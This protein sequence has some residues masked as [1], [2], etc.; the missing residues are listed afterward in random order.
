MSSRRSRSR[1]STA[2][3][4]AMLDQ[5]DP[6]I[7]D[8]PDETGLDALR[9]RP[10]AELCDEFASRREEATAWLCTLSAAQLARG[11]RHEVAGAITIRDVLH[12]LAYHDL[13]HVAQSARLIAARM[14]QRRGAMRDA[15]PD[16]GG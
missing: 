8:I 14:E 1:S 12:H 4:R 2:P 15:F 10:L 11:G 9:G 13:L 16:D 6:S 5:D 7:P 3:A